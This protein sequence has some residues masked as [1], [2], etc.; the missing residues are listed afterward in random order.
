MSLFSDMLGKYV[1]KKAYK[2]GKS[3]AEHKKRIF[4][5]Y[6]NE[7][8][9]MPKDE[10]YFLT[11]LSSLYIDE[12]KAERVISE[13]A[14]G[15]IGGFKII[16]EGDPFCLRSIIKRMLAIES[17]HVWGYRFSLATIDVPHILCEAY[18]AVDDVIPEEL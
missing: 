2:W 1:L 15:R 18:I 11:I 14:D 12:I 5:H 9:D 3:R 17:S 10:L 16:G 7:F 8:P 6:Q 13:V 4:L